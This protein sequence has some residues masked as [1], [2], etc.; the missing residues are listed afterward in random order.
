VK[1]IVDPVM[2]VNLWLLYLAWVMLVLTI[3]LTLASYLYALDSIRLGRENAPRFFLEGDDAVASV[4]LA[5]QTKMRRLRY[6]VVGLFVASITSLALF[7]V[8]NIHHEA[9]AMTT[10]NREPKR[11]ERGL[12]SGA[13]E[14]FA[15]PTPEPAKPQTPTPPAATQSGEPADESPTGDTSSA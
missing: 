3:A 1:E 7:V 11:T 12:S 14:T 9:N 5:H 4:P 2:A 15:T 6:A 10:E 8:L 13:F